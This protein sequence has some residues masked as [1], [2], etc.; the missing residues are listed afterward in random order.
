M[1]RLAPLLALLGVAVAAGLV[2]VVVA[3]R[4]DPKAPP[5]SPEAFM[6]RI[7]RLTTEE[8]Y[9]EA[10]S[11]LHPGHQAIAPR[12]RF[13]SCRT[14]DTTISGFRF[15]SARFLSKRLTR[16]DSPGIP[17]HTSTQVVLRFRVA[18]R[19][20]NALPPTDATVRAVWIDTRWAWVLPDREIP[21]F[22]AGR[23]PV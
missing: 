5:E 4:S 6:A 2:V 19:A 7:L 1:R 3:G 23:C 18:D 14:A 8:R 13:I 20:G 22:R 15:V 11:S 12:E 10:W 9:A 17:Q 16:I 21:T